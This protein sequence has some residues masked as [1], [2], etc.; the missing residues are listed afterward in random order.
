MRLPDYPEGAFFIYHYPVCLL[1]VQLELITVYCL[2]MTV[3]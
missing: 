1:R 2:L 3:H